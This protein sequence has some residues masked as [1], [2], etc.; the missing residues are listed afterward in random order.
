MSPARIVT[1]GEAML[2]LRADGAGWRMGYGGDTLNMAIHLARMGFPTR[3]LS[4]LGADP[5]ST[6][7]RTEDWPAEGLDTSLVLVDP[8]RQ[9]GLYA[10]TLGGDGER[11]FTYW[12]ADSAASQLFDHDEITPALEQAADCDLFLFSLISLAVVP[13]TRRGALLALASRVRDGG[14]RVAFDGNFRPAL[15][16][17]V[18]AARWWRDAAIE[19]SDFGLPSLDDEVRMGARDDPTAVAE[20]WRSAGAGEIVVKLG[21]RGCL[22]GDGTL[23]APPAPLAALDTSGAGDAFNAAY[24][25]ARLRGADP[26]EAAIEGQALAGWT[27]LRA[28][29]IPPRDE[30][31]PYASPGRPAP[32]VAANPS[33]R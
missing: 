16:P 18:A 29:A 31:A 12:R 6:R 14:G 30:Q 33:L 28:G 10:I 26:H 9:P 7:L 1:A 19:R 17:D 3:F 27:L 25:G 24:L 4:A 20:H 22:L 21:A 2:E 15:W 32:A 8:R 11:S 13:E 23:V 5:F